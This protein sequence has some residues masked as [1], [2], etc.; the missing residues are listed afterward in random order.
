M[1]TANKFD[2]QLIIDLMVEFKNE[3]DIVELRELNNVEYWNRLL[4]TILAGA[5]IIYL[6]PNKGLIMAIMTPSIWCNKTLQLSELA[7]YVKPEYRNTSLGYRL[8]KKYVDYGNELK[9]SGRIKFFTMAKM[10]TSPNIKYE[11]FGFRKLD[12]NWIQ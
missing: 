11:K 8:L 1:R 2:K 12:E 3:S 5:G 10:V 6:E 9:A 7:W 4:D